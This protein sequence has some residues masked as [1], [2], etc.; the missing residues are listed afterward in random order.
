MRFIS[1][2]VVG[3]FSSLAVAADVPGSQDLPLLPRPDDA[4]I[5]DYRQAAQL[6]RLYPMG[7]IRKI[8]NRIRSESQLNPRGELTAVT[9]SA[10]NS[11][12]TAVNCPRGLSSPSERIRL[13]ILRI[14]P[15]GYSRS[16]CAA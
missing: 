2:L 9:C 14:E 1:L 11:Y 6:E 10:G 4:Q 7:S 13:L 15:I 16:S 3:C 12:V 5:V 8:S